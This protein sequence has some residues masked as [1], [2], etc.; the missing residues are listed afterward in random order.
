LNDGRIDLS[1]SRF[2][3]FQGVSGSQFLLN[4]LTMFP[5][6][7]IFKLVESAL[8]TFAGELAIAL[9]GIVF[10]VFHD[11]WIKNVILVRIRKRKHRNLEGFRKLSY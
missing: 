10:T 6:L 9:P 3:N 1:K 5:P 2:F 4:I 8:G 11:W 7:I